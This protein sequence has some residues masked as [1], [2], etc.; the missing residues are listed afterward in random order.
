MPTIA[1]PH[2]G[3][4]SMAQL[5]TN[6]SPATYLHAP[7][8]HIMNG[9]SPRGRAC[10]LEWVISSD[11]VRQRQLDAHPRAYQIHMSLPIGVDGAPIAPVGRCLA[12]P[13]HARQGR[14]PVPSEHTRQNLAAPVVSGWPLGVCLQDLPQDREAEQ[15]DPH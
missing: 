8:T 10:A 5:M 3:D 11:G 4:A 13:R 6:A 7:D 1:D 12:D 15:I 14:D 9:C 2:A